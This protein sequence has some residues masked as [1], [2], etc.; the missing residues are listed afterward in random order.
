LAENPSQAV[1]N[2]GSPSEGRSGVARSLF[3]LDDLPRLRDQSPHS[4]A[5][6]ILERFSLLLGHTSA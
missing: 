1:Q 3:R 6:L 5:P 2:S 4:P